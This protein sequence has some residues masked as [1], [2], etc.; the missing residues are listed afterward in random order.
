VPLSDI[1]LDEALVTARNGAGFT[2]IAQTFEQLALDPD[3]ILALP[4]LGARSLD[5]LRTRLQTAILAAKVVEPEPVAVEVA[6]SEPAPVTAEGAL[7]PAAEGEAGEAAAP[8]GEAVVEGE[9]GLV[10]GAAPAAEGAEEEEEEEGGA[11][12]KKKGKKK[13]QV[14]V[15]F[16]PD[17]GVT[18]AHRKRKASRVRGFDAP[19]E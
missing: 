2:N 4:E 19:E 3:P 14:T 6:A 18:L 12:K 5:D 15:E 8:E 17:L 10:P 13:K 11:G 9:A 1:G 16:D 7:A